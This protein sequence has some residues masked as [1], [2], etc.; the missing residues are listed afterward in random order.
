[1]TLF[2]TV[3]ILGLA[4]N[5]FGGYEDK[6]RALPVEPSAG[7]K[8]PTQYIILNVKDVCHKPRNVFKNLFP[9]KIPF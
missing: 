3:L 5:V 1:M 9:Q 4:F 8:F 7:S 2:G 6:F